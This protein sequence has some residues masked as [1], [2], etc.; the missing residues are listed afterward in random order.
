MD[1]DKQHDKLEAAAVFFFVPSSH[2]GADFIVAAVASFFA[3]PLHPL[4]TLHE[5]GYLWDAWVEA[6]KEGRKGRTNGRTTEGREK[7]RK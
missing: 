1:P 3:H 5:V 6:R 4:K 7:G 2:L